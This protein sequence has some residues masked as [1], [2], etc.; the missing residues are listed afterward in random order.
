MDT[1]WTSSKPL[2]SRVMILPPLQGEGKKEGD[3]RGQHRAARCNG[4]V[5][6]DV[7]FSGMLP[8]CLSRKRDPTAKV[9]LLLA[10]STHTA[11]KISGRGGGA[12]ESLWWNGGTFSRSRKLSP[13]LPLPRGAACLCTQGYAAGHPGHQWCKT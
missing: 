11:S 2:P 4:W 3:H 13:F 5:S 8:G 7:I 10:A 12:A 1:F 6:P 9:F